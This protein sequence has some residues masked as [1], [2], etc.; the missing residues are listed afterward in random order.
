VP[1]IA[2]EFRRGFATARTL[3]CDV[4]L[5][6]HPAM[7][8]MKEKYAALGTGRANPY[9]DPEGYRIELDVT[10]AMFKAVLASQERSSSPQ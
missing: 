5:A 8:G 10:E 1:H 7:F 4:P 9:V 3:P 2:D 6:S